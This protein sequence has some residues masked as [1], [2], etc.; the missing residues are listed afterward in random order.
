MVFLIVVVIYFILYRTVVG[1]A[2]TAVLC[3]RRRAPVAA[4]DLYIPLKMTK[5]DTNIIIL[6]RH[7]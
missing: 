2:T 4:R 1:R 7:C 6:Y 5:H 3:V